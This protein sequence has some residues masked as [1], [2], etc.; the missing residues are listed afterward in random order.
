MTELFQE[1]EALRVKRDWSYAQLADAIAET[2]TRSRDQDC[3]R[4]ICCGETTRPNARTL[5][6]LRVFLA[7]QAKSTPA[8]K[9]R[10]A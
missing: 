8:R 2:T 1:L 10:V 4:K 7:A 6:I 3:W 9:R 5:D